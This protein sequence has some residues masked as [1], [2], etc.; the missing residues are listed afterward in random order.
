MRN[1]DKLPPKPV[2]EEYRPEITR[3]PSLTLWRRLG[4][5]LLHWISLFLLKITTRASVSGLENFPRQGPALIT[6]NHLGDLDAL[7]CLA[8]FP[9][10]ADYLSKA[11]FYD[12]PVLGWIQRMYGTI[13]VHRGQPDRRALRAALKG[14]EEGRMVA[15]APEGRESVSGSL[16]PGTGGAAFLAMK[17]EVPIV[18]ITLTGTQNKRIYGNL[19]RLRRSDISMTIGLPYWLE[20]GSDHKQ[21]IQDGTDQIMLHLAAQLPPEYQ[22]VYRGQIEQMHAGLNPDMQSDQSYSKQPS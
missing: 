1:P 9:N 20:T 5:N 2:T 6:V 19:Q 3:L 22:G 18:P 17:A 21:A 13:W 7:F 8:Y 14:F 10:R 4:R 12:F 11:E 16:E 15:I